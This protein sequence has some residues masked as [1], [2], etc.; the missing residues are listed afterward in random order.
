MP[1]DQDP[2]RLRVSY[3]SPRSLLGEFTRSVGR[4]AVALQSRRPA[5]IGTRF[6]FELTAEGVRDKVEVV[7]EVVRC[8]P[9]VEAPGRFELLVRYDA[10]ADRRGLDEALQWIADAHQRDKRRRAHPRIPFYIQATDGT[11]GS[12][13]YLVRNLSRGGAGVEIDSGDPPRALQAGVPFLLELEPAGRPALLLHGEV[14]WRT[15]PLPG[16]AR[17][18]NPTFGVRFGTLRPDAAAMLEKVLTLRGLPPA[19]WVARVS[20][21]MEAVSRMP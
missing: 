20:F 5:Q 18:M 12:A 8:T 16:R 15:R 14:V 2:V 11:P 1:R 21:G 9:A 4:Q 3:Q 13:R 10:G 7:G 17:S 6:L 19:P